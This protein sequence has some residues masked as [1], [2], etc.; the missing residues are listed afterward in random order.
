MTASRI[1]AALRLDE[2]TRARVLRGRA[3]E[4]IEHRAIHGDDAELAIDPEKVIQRDAQGN[5][6][7]AYRTSDTVGLLR[8]NGTIDGACYAAGLEFQKDF[9][10]AGHV[11]LRAL[12]L[13]RVPTGARIDVSERVYLA[14]NRVWH[15]IEAMG[16]IASPMTDVAWA[17]IGEGRCISEYA[18]TASISG[19]RSVHAQLARGL[20]I[21]ALQVLAVAYRLQGK[22]ARLRKWRSRD[23]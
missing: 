5:Y 18:Q 9:Y 17:V 21:G 19:I 20:L 7:A 13:L 16:G 23:A 11:G 15:A 12:P 22:S 2:G 1:K 10:A 14:R 3:A 4:P 8:R 6:S